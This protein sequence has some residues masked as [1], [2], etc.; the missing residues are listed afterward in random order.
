MKSGALSP[1]S[2]VEEARAKG[3]LILHFSAMWTKAFLSKP[4]RGGYTA[5]PG[6]AA[7]ECASQ[8]MADSEPI[9]MFALAS[10]DR[11][12]AVRHWRRAGF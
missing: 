6:L 3:L 11:I 1:L 9:S 5:F 4:A 7:T 8:V 2:R 12:V 10:S